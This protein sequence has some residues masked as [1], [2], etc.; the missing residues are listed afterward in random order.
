M[1]T[2]TSDTLHYKDKP[3]KMQ[4]SSLF[5]KGHRMVNVASSR[6]PVTRFEGRFCI[7]FLST[8]ILH[9]YLQTLRK[10][11]KSQDRI[12]PHYRLSLTSV[13]YWIFTI[14]F[15]TYFSAI[16]VLIPILGLQPRDK[17]AMLG[18]NTI[19]LFPEEFT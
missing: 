3:N 6:V 15:N 14:Q 2:L 19:E 1:G 13:Q 11:L 17:A 4:Q 16:L 9:L 5:N 10:G 18:V 7:A 12:F 8:L